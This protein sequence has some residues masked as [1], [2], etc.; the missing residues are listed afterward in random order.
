MRSP[1]A[2]SVPSAMSVGPAWSVP[3]K[4]TPTYGAFALEHSSRKMSC[5]LG[6]ASRPPYS[7]GHD[8]PA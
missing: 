5:S 3:T 6:G 7:F 4:F 1:S 8:I 2:P